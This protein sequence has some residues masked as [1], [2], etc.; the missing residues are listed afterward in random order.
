MAAKANSIA[1]PSFCI[2]DSGLA[3]PRPNVIVARGLY[4]EQ[5]ENKMR[6]ALALALALIATPAYSQA[7]MLPPAAKPNVGVLPP[8][9]YDVPFTGKLKVIR[10]DAFLMQ[11]LCPKTA[12]PIT[13]GC[14]YA[15]ADK[16]ECIVIMAEDGIIYDAGWTPQ[17]VWRHERGHCGGWGADHKGSRPATPENLANK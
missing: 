6:P 1:G 12:L 17:L 7:T 8:V 5:R 16:S 4:R 11:R 15:A 14:S 3:T 13:L 10:G 9:E 2:G